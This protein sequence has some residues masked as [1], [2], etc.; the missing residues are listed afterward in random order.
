MSLPRKL[1]ILLV[2]TF[3]TI[4]FLSGFI[5][6]KNFNNKIKLSKE[7]KEYIKKKSEVKIAILKD[8]M[9]FSYYT[10]GKSIGLSVDILEK[11]SQKTGLK[12]RFIPDDWHNNLRK[13][14]KCKVDLITDISYK[15]ERLKYTLYTAPY[16]EIPIVVFARND[17]GNYHDLSDLNGK[18]VGILKDIFYADQLKKNYDSNFIELD[19]S[20]TLIKHL[21]YGKID[22]CI[23]SF[24]QANMYIQKNGFTN[25]KILGECNL[26]DIKREDLRFGITTKKPILFEIINRAYE[27]ISYEELA[28]IKDKWLR[29]N[30]DKNDNNSDFTAREIS[31]IRR[32]KSVD[33]AVIK[34]FRPFSFLDNKTM[35]GFSIDLLKLISEKTGLKFNLIPDKWYKNLAKFK[36]GKIDMIDA[37]SFKEERAKFTLYTKPYYKIPIVIFS[38]TDLEEC[39][40]ID[41]FIGKKIGI[42]KDIYFKSELEK[43]KGLNI[44]EFDD[45]Q[46]QIA[47]LS[48]G[49]IDIALGD[50]V[51][52]IYFSKLNGFINLKIVNDFKMP[53]IGKEDLR[54][55]INKDNK[56]LFSI[57]NKGLNLITNSEINEIKNRWFG[58]IKGK[59]KKIVFTK[60]E[61]DFIR[62]HQIIK[63]GNEM[64]WLPYDYVE[65]NK[66]KGISIEYLN[67]LAKK[68]GIKLQY[69]HNLKWSELEK[70]FKHKEIDVLPAF[71]E[72][73]Y[74]RKYTNFTRPYQ[75][76][77]LA[78]FTQKGNHTIKSISD[79]AG[80]KVAM[81]K[82][83]GVNK[84]ILKLFPKIKPVYFDYVKKTLK[85]VS[86]GDVDATV[87]Y[88]LLVYYY[89]KQK[90]I[91]NLR[92]VQYLDDYKSLWEISAL[93]IGVRK[94]WKIFRDIL[95]KTMDAVSEKE[96]LEIENKWKGNLIET[97]FTK[98]LNL[99]T[100]EKKFIEKHPVLRM[101]NESDYAPYNFFENG[102]AKGYT[103]DFINLLA[104]KIG[105]KLD[106]IT[107]KPWNEY[108]EMMKNKELDIIGNIVKTE[109]RSK[110]MIF[111]KP[112]YKDPPIIFCDKR[113]SLLNTLEQ[114]NGKTVAVNKGYWYEEILRKNYPKINILLT[115]NNIDGIKA[116]Y[117]G[118]ADAI[119]G[120]AP[121]IQNLIISNGFSE[122]IP[123]GQ[124]KFKNIKDYYDRIGVRKDWPILRDIL[125]KAMDTVTFEERQK[126]KK[127]W[128][129]N[130]VDNEKSTRLELSLKEKKYL[131]NRNPI[132]MGVDPNWLPYEAIDKNGNHIGIA[133]DY[134]KLFEK[135]IGKKIELVPTKSWNQTIEFGK[136]RKCDIFSAAAETPER[137][138]YMSFTTPYL[139]FPTVIVT[140]SKVKFIAETK[141]IIN[142]KIAMIENY[143]ISELLQNKYPKMNIIKVKNIEEG[144]QLVNSGK[145]F[146]Y[147]GALPPISYQI[148]KTGMV[149]LKIAGKLETNFYLSIAVRNDDPTLLKIM[150]KAVDSITPEDRQKINNKWLSVNYN[151]K[152]DYSL[153]WKILAVIFLIIITILYWNRK[154]H[155]EIERR[156]IIEK[157]LKETFYELKIAKEKAEDANKAKSEFLANISHELRTPLNAVIGFSELL[158]TMM[159]EGKEKS[160]VLSIK[161]AGKS[162]LTLINDILDLSKIESGKLKIAKGFVNIENLINEMKLIFSEQLKNKGIKFIVNID[163]KMPK[164]ILSDE[165]R[166]RQI[167]LNLIGNAQKFTEKGMIKVNVEAKEIDRK[168]NTMTL[169][170]SVEDTGVGIAPDSLEKIFEAFQQQDGQDAKKYGGTGLGLSISRKL[171]NAMGG[172]LN[173]KS[174]LGK[175]SSFSLILRNIEIPIYDVEENNNFKEFD[176]DFN[177]INYQEKQIGI[178]E[179]NDYQRE[180]LEDILEKTGIDVFI[181]TDIREFNLADFKPDL[182]FADLEEIEQKNIQPEKIFGNIPTVYLVSSISTYN[183]ENISFVEKPIDPQKILSVLI[184]HFGDPLVSKNKNNHSEINKFDFEKILD[185]KELSQILN[186]DILP[187]CEN[188]KKAIVIS[189]IK[190]F[191]EKLISIADKFNFSLLKNSGENF[192]KY[193][194]LFDTD[195]IEKELDNLENLITEVGKSSRKY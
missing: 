137:A 141:S 50:M 77:A 113:N 76:G 56:I 156:K 69:I 29:L 102:E 20:N 9:P 61:K 193:A 174:T 84:E 115:S 57:I 186:N 138:K 178:F 28:F 106:I 18:N 34:N 37:I 68:I 119:I 118:Q 132:K 188:L 161:T 98:K 117:F 82:G 78:V 134:F 140:K 122:V 179:K 183:E 184:Y 31:Y 33:V 71:Y 49:K 114:L 182:I 54:L 168:N 189:E 40:E 87:N 73:N 166:L 128:V 194:D 22:A 4:S 74:R 11:I 180:L 163:K 7:E 5:E 8:Y 81:V 101:E 99:T 64:D 90:Q 85:S 100:Q 43:I 151:T 107:G 30:F 139:S 103:I 23:I 55:G 59:E 62:N 26:K 1:S 17:F 164:V 3:S 67:L 187:S 126:L 135:R 121:I 91:T 169:K 148:Q 45:T 6:N 60:E 12:F 83:F 75:S 66:A 41:C 162:L 10:N 38:R 89:A 25:I 120:K 47:A 79:L 110:Y 109:D 165:I 171:A 124:A 52:G 160:Y 16:Y 104:K 158:S 152:F 96:F 58:I 19:D 65:D 35:R 108:L 175:G 157:S 142:K 13:F 42:I 116:V 136:T 153:F 80:K 150:Q 149:N 146:G 44:V 86:T 173:V 63:V 88:P 176:F 105:I 14:Q 15:K 97:N 129:F 130:Y 2:F 46:S 21:A 112:V 27:D 170:I 24:N 127:K 154:L 48:Y 181:I 123:T 172:E 191:G 94:D 190:S 51:Q 92:I 192:I 144:F 167:L 32:K 185:I 36:N 93:H 133:A 95:E 177:K 72:N 159:K 155:D 147:V 111:T 131:E 195:E 143:A 125:Q 53:G 70:K 145:A 39:P